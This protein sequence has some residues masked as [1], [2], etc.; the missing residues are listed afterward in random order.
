MGRLVKSACAARYCVIPFLLPPLKNPCRTRA[1]KA[2]QAGRRRFDPGRPL[3]LRAVTRRCYRPLGRP[4]RKSPDGREDA[5]LSIKKCGIG[6]LAQQ[7]VA[8]AFATAPP[9]AWAA[10]LS[11]SEFP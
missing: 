4:K 7:K 2:S 1:R 6:E 8:T 11:F 9:L 5:D 3:S 10:P